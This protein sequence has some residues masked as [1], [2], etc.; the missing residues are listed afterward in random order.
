[1]ELY[2]FFEDDLKELEK[3]IVRLHEKLVEFRNKAVDT[4]ARRDRGLDTDATYNALSAMYDIYNKQLTELSHIR[5]HAKD[6]SL[7]KTEEKRVSVGKTVIVHDMSVNKTIILK[8]RSYWIS[9]NGDN[10]VAYSAPL[11]DL[12]MKARTG[13]ICEG[14][15]GGTKKKY[16]IKQ[17]I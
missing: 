5:N 8:I 1:M 9:N 17:I 11:P 14:F 10:R 15:I 13:E 16:E 7:L 6:F 4:L 3:E 12:L 2:Y